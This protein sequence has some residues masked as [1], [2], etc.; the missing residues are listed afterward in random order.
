MAGFFERLAARC[1]SQETFLCVG[2]DPRASSAAEAEA[3]C[4]SLID[5]THDVACCF[6]P[7]AA[8]FEAHG[9]AGLEALKRVIAKVHAVG[10]LALLDCKRGDIGATAEAY[11][12]ACYDDLGA[13]C[14]TLSPYLGYDA[15]APFV[16]GPYAGKGCFVLCATSN[17]SAEEVQ[18]DEL[19]GTV[20][21]LCG[22]AWAARTAEASRPLGLVVGATKPAAVAAARR[23]N[24]AA[25]ILAPGVGAQGASASDVVAAALA[26]TPRRR[27]VPPPRRAVSRAVANAPDPRAK[28]AE[29]RDEINAAVECALAKPPAPS[30]APHQRAFIDCVLDTGALKFGAFTLK[31]GRASPYFFN[32]GKFAYNRKEAKD[33]GEGGTLVGADVAGKKV[34]L[35]DDVISAGTAVREATGILKQAGAILVAVCVAVDREEVTG[36]AAPPEP[37]ARGSPPPAQRDL[38]V[39][40]VPIVTLTDLLAYLDAAKGGD[41][42]TAKHADAVRDYRAVYGAPVLEPARAA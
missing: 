3:L 8:F 35:V 11:A 41:A 21:A 28:A 36:G 26:A 23:A 17:G 13:D 12:K 33:H 7:N 34:L 9:S 5:A 15:I 20:A 18:S 4:V 19:R 29:L 27:C 39:P 42:E 6:K 25:W 24:G 2:L 10:G 22:G 40:V 31:S 32:A 30:I 16:T 14:V 38:G 1:A 37:G